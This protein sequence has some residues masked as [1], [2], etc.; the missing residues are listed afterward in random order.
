MLPLSGSSDFSSLPSKVKEPSGAG[1]VDPLPVL[2]VVL[3]LGV[4]E[5]LLLEVGV[6]LLDVVLR[7]ILLSSLSF[8]K[9]RNRIIIASII[10]AITHTR[11]LFLFINIV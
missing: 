4:V 6:W 10:P 3:A 8:L 5:L 1:S 2:G 11:W 7:S 9:I